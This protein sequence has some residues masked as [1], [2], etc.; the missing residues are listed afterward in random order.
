MEE[1]DLAQKSAARGHAK[2][3]I[4][5]IKNARSADQVASL[6]AEVMNLIHEFN[7]DPGLMAEVLQAVAE[8]EIVR[9]Q[10][11]KSAVI[12]NPELATYLDQ[13]TARIVERDK[14]YVKNASFLESSYQVTKSLM[15]DLDNPDLGVAGKAFDLLLDNNKKENINKAARTF[16]GLQNNLDEQIDE[17]EVLKKLNRGLLPPVHADRYNDLIQKREEHKEKFGQEMASRLHVG[18]ADNVALNLADKG[19]LDK[20]ESDLNRLAVFHVLKEEEYQQQLFQGGQNVTNKIIAN[21]DR[22]QEAGGIFNEE[23]DNL[24]QKIQ[25]LKELDIAAKAEIIKARLKAEDRKAQAAKGQQSKE[26]EQD[27]KQLDDKPADPRNEKG[28]SPSIGELSKDAIV[29]KKE[30]LRT[31]QPGLTDKQLNELAIMEI[32][33]AGE[34][35][36]SSEAKENKVA[37]QNFEEKKEAIR[38]EQ[39]G[40]S[41]LK[42][43]EMAAKD[44]KSA[45]SVD[46]S[47]ELAGMLKFKKKKQ[48]QPAIIDEAQKAES[49][50]A[51]KNQEKL[52]DK[53]LD[54]KP[55]VEA[56]IPIKEEQKISSNNIVAGV[57]ISTE[58]AGMLK[59]KK[60]KPAQDIAQK[61]EV[62]KLDAAIMDKKDGKSV[63]SKSD[64]KGNTENDDRKAVLNSYKDIALNSLPKLNVENLVV[65]SKSDPKSMKNEAAS[66]ISDVKEN[67]KA[68]ENQAKQDGAQKSSA[69]S[70]DDLAAAIQGIRDNKDHKAPIQPEKPKPEQGKAEKS[71]ADNKR[72]SK[73]SGMGM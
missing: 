11:N 16:I 25:E 59:F 23:K 69:Q 72:N 29:A 44:S 22:P 34:K 12:S 71:A 3:I 43:N 17:Y 2:A 13:I 56:Q 27:K 61:F 47:P 18:V 46:I 35:V 63:D 10:S 42:L 40:I 70:G 36:V 21:K 24:S 31:E 58:L 9:S 7:L 66:I 51:A 54:N 50:A 53:P 1:R 60:K 55:L 8:N 32:K 45:A 48:V 68:S 26:N 33:N 64:P 62:Q 49:P 15:K 57:D 6:T 39:P 65:D 30:E 14:E 37:A 52:E 19:L 41:E 5:Q 4:G 28:M 38:Q 73:S 20:K 67:I